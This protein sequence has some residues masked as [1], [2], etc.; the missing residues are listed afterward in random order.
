[1]FADKFNYEKEGTR[2]RDNV[3][4]S[5]ELEKLKSHPTVESTNVGHKTQVS[6][7]ELN[8]TNFV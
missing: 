4:M 5:W 3:Q 2:K 1:M 7:S 8:K 6:F